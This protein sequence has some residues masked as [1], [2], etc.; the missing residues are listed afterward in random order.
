MC[1]STSIIKHLLLT[2]SGLLAFQTL[3]AQ[4]IVSG[5]ITTE[6]GDPLANVLVAINGS[7]EQ[8]VFSRNDGYY[9]FTAPDNGHIV[10]TP[11]ASINVLNGVTTLDRV[12]ISRHLLGVELLDSP[13]KLIA[14]DVD[15]D[16][17]LTGLDTL[18]IADLIFGLIPSL[19]NEKSW[20]FIEEAYV[21]PDPTN[22]FLED[23]PEEVIISNVVSD[24]T[25]NFIG[26]KLGD[27][28]SSAQGTVG[29]TATNCDGSPISSISDLNAIEGL[30]VFPN[31]FIDE[32]NLE[33]GKDYPTVSVEIFTS[34]GKKISN[35]NF[36]NTNTI[37]LTI[38]NKT[39][40]I[41][42]IKV[43]AEQK[44]SWVSVVKK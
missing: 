20:R 4:N 31:P 27:I 25:V 7:V 11:C 15:Q 30:R 44:V 22:P 32:I 21:F 3:V 24:T 2:L 5:Y 6:G 17:A 29:N 10:L 16:D 12:L 35:S 36:N 42:F 39:S 33:L 38:E 18:L 43:T 37:K 1:I 26:V 8:S 23:Y 13:Y 14:A 34:A 19:P 41:Y 28:N 9:E 40:G